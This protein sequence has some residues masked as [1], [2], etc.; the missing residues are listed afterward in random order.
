MNEKMENFV[1]FCKNCGSFK[2]DI[3]EAINDEHVFVFECLNCDM[4]EE[5]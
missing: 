2:I 5:I 4:K 1:V 3:F